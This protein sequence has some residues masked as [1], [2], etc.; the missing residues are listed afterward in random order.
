M[1]ASEA[2]PYAKTGGLADVIG[3]LP[4]ALRARG[5]HV[6]VVMPLY[7]SSAAVLGPAERVYDRMPINLGTVIYD[8]SIRRVVQNDVTFFFVEEDSLYGRDELY[9]EAGKDYPDNHIRFG[10]LCRAALGV[11]R[12]LFRPE[13][14]HLHDWQAALAAPM[15]R[16]FFRGDPTFYGIKILLT[17]HN[18]GYQGI[19]DRTALT[20]LG[21]PTSLYHPDAMEFFGRINLLKGGIVFSDAISTVSKGYAHEIQRPDLGFGLDGL[22]RDRA[23]VLTGIVNGVDYDVWS[24]K[25]DPFIA[26]YYDA[27]DLRGKRPCKKDL[28]E[29][30]GLPVDLERP[31][32]GMVSRFVDQKGFDL[33][34]EVL[35][36]LAEEDVYIVALGTGEPRYEQMLLD[37]AAAFPDKLAVRIAYDD[38]LAHKIEAGADIFLMPSRYEPCGLNQIYSLRYGTVP[39]VRATGGLDDT[40]EEETGFKFT[41]ILRGGAARSSP[42]R[43]GRLPR[44]R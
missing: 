35:P 17:I 22:L 43:S 31:A 33:I 24:P 44:S 1:V 5:E 30:F 26:A 38:A 25:K 32:I 4:A 37:A 6:A 20:E 29:S 15:A 21:L 23:D 16:R 13:I 9:T 42:G 7:K 3:A 10:V 27:E 2:T 12:S 14:L 28:L 40:I 18:L 19:F 41:G 8:V 11:V 36:L 34:E 39:V